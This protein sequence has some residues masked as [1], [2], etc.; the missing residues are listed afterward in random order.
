MHVLE[1]RILSAL[2]F[3]CDLFAEVNFLPELVHPI[4]QTFEGNTL[5]AFE[6]AATY[7][8]CAPLSSLPHPSRSLSSHFHLLTC[9]LARLPLPP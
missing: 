1:R 8:S 2:A 7:L 4:V 3:W 6:V 9:S 5:D